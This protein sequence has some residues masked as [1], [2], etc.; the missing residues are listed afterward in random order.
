M[1]ASIIRHGV[2]LS[3]ALRYLQPL[4]GAAASAG[5]YLAAAALLFAT[6]LFLYRF[7]PAALTRLPGIWPGALA[8]AAGFEAVP[9]GFSLYVPPDARRSPQPVTAWPSH[10]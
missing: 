5:V 1:L 9:Y 6:F 4:A 2:H 10:W 3:G 8:A 7:V